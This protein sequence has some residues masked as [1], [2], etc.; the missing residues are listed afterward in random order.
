MLWLKSNLSF[1]SNQNKIGNTSSLKYTHISKVFFTP[2]LCTHFYLTDRLPHQ[3]WLCHQLR[4]CHQG[5]DVITNS[6]R[7]MGNSVIIIPPDNSA[8]FMIIRPAILEFFI[9]KDEHHRRWPSSRSMNY[10]ITH[11]QRIMVNGI[12][13]VPLYDFEPSACHLCYN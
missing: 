10:H 3:G 11:A 1:Q 8:N 2:H 13:I 9:C 12:L 7:I 5:H 4:W 6:Q